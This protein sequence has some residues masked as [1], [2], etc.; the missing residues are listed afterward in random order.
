MNNWWLIHIVLCLLSKSIVVSKL[1]VGLRFHHS[2]YFVVLWKFQIAKYAHGFSMALSEAYINLI[3]G[4]YNLV[5]VE[6]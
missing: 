2:D 5:M 3:N 4:I 6:Y 1:I